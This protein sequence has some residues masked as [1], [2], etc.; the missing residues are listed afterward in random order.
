[1]RDIDAEMAA[2]ER[3]VFHRVCRDCNVPIEAPLVVANRDE[4]GDPQCNAC[5]A[6][7]SAP[8][9]AETL[10]VRQAARVL[11]NLCDELRS[12]CDAYNFERMSACDLWMTLPDG[13]IDGG[14]SKLQGEYLEN[15]IARWDL[16]EADAR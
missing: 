5:D 10:R 2:A 12:F 11:A 13:G 8:S 15:F 1:M 6:T 14:L 9:T 4:E 7:F 3:E 16:A